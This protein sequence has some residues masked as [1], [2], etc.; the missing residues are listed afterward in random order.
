MKA[1]VIV[2]FTM[3][4]I[5]NKEDLDGDL[6][7]LEKMVKHLIKEEGIFGLVDDKYKILKIEEYK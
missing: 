1:R 4:N 6:D 3:R 5:C 2:E 7:T